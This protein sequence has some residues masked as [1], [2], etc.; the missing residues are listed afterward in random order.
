MCSVAPVVGEV[1]FG[2]G[3]GVDFW[4]L[5][6]AFSLFAAAFLLNCFAVF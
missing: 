1:V 2:G 5:L 4:L 3:C 6:L